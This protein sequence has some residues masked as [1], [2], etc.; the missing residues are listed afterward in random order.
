METGRKNKGGIG[1][2]GRIRR[3]F[4]PLRQIARILPRNINWSLLS[5]GGK[6]SRRET[7]INVSLDDSRDIPKRMVGISRVFAG[8]LI[9]IEGLG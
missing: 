6:N 7:G 1:G 3:R 2:G 8:R 5:G 4:F 9:K